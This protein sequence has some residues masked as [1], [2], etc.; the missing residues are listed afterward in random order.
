MNTR[1]AFVAALLLASA[2]ALAQVTVRDAWVRATVPAQ[3]TS[4]AF[5]TIT[6]AR[7]A[8]I[9]AVRSPVAATVEMHQM[10]MRST[11]MNMRAVDAIALPAGK[12]VDFG[13]AGY[14]VMLMELRRQLKAGETVPL[15]LLVEEKNKKR[16]TVTVQATVR[17]LGTAAH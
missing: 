1:L 11:T 10:D 5:L 12:T 17:P 3:K 16:L 9:V 6:S 2:G 7:D 13:A 4:G 14:H 15:E 8:Q